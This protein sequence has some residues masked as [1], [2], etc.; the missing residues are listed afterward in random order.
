MTFY[1]SANPRM[2]IDSSGNIQATVNTDN[3]YEFGRVHLNYVGHT[4][5]AGFSHVDQ[6]SGTSY[7]LLQN[8]SGQTYLNAPSGQDLRFRIQNNDVGAFDGTSFNF[9]VGTADPD[10][11]MSGTKGI[12]IVSAN[13]AALGLSNGTTHWLTYLTTNADRYRI[14]N[15]VSNEVMTILSGGNV[16]IAN[17]G[18]NHLF[19]LGNSNSLTVSG[20]YKMFSAGAFGVLFRNSY[21]SYIAGNTQY[22]ASGGWVNK[23]GGKKSS[24]I[25]FVD[26]GIEFNIGTGTTQGGASDLTEK[27]KTTT[28]G[29]TFFVPAQGTGDGDYTNAQYYPYKVD[30]DTQSSDYWRIPHL[31]GHSTVA[32]VYNY[33]TGKNV[34]WGEPNDTGTYFLR[35][36]TL[37]VDTSNNNSAFFL[38]SQTTNIIEFGNATQTNYTDLILRSNSGAGEIF[39]AGTAYTNWGGAS[40]FNI[41]NSNGNISFHPGGVDNVVQFKNNGP[42]ITVNFDGTNGGNDL[43]GYAILAQSASSYQSTIGAHNLGDGYANLNL[44]S[45]SSGSH[46]M[47]H[48]SKRPSGNS[49]ELQYYYYNGSTFAQRFTFSTGG[50]FTATGDVIAFSDKRVK[51]NIKTI[52]NGLEKVS[53]LRGVSYNRT[54]I[55][56]KSDKIGVIAQEV[57]EVLPEVVDYDKNNDTYGV[58]YG[59]MAGVFIEAI[60]EL[61]AEIE[62]LKSNKCNCNK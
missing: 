58:D 59:K 50:N 4:D 5:H 10:A 2:R 46:I 6:D 38:S 23:Y 8:S 62:E 21:D 29:T 18:P 19:E 32:G 55:D 53:K 16:G 24:L 35:G 42:A 33:E 14:W 26:G 36:R 51:T 57:K 3:T 37:N 47:W 60:K 56:D 28:F 45:I 34:Y 54:D 13:Y 49:H 12:S 48:I 31:S 15:S 41:Y 11:Q 9:G 17:D 39:K 43:G 1:T 40:S 20:S 27:L 7:A 52:D 30:A 25:G 22:A 44:S 61:K